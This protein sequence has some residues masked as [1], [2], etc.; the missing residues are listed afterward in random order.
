MEAIRK[1]RVCRLGV[2]GER[3]PVFVERPIRGEGTSGWHGGAC[4]RS[5]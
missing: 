2:G 3:V 4:A 1:S 5:L